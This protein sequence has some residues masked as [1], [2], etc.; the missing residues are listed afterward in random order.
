MSVNRWLVIGLAGLAVATAIDVAAGDEFV[1][2]IL[3]LLPVLGIAARAGRTEVAVIGTLATAVA[4]ASGVWDEDFG[5][6]VHVLGALSVAIGAGMAYLVVQSREQAE[7]ARVGTVSAERRLDEVLGALAE[8]IT[9]QDSDGQVVFANQAAADMIGFGS[10]KELIEA[11]AQE[12]AARFEMRRP[13]GSA[14]TFDELPGLRVLA[15]EPFAELLTRSVVKDTGEAHWFRTRATRLEDADGAYAVNVIEDVTEQREAELRQRYLTE[16]GELLS[17]SLDYEHT[18]QQVL[19]LVV[20]ELADWA[21]IEIPDDHEDMEQVAIAHVDPA[22]IVWAKELRERYPPDPDAPQGP[23]AIMR[24]GDPLLMPFIPPELLEEAAQDEEHLRLIRE[25]ELRSAMAVPMRSAGRPVGVLSLI[26]TAGG[27]IYDEDDLAFATALADRAGVAVE[28]ARL[29]TELSRVAETLQASLLPERLPDI[30]RWE[31]AAEYRAGE[32]GSSVGG[33]FYDVV[34]SDGGKHIALLGDVSGK[35]V[36]AA[37]LT[38]LVRHTART[39]AFFHASP[40]DILA[41]VNRA[42]RLQPQL[43]PVTMACASC[44]EDGGVSLAIGG[45]PLPV[46]RRADGQAERIGSFGLLLGVSEPYPT[47]AESVVRLERGDTLLIFTDGVTDTPGED[48]RFG[49]DRLR[50]AVATAPPEPA[51]LLA[52]ISRALDDYQS[53]TVA[54]DRAM[55]ALRYTG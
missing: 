8:A 49:D 15:G 27:R 13:D 23:R 7:Q 11:D 21:A 29:Y 37:A 55:L 32:R 10:P 1:L 5:E 28:N 33:D 48:G 25:L 53:G 42:L 43:S 36:E 9:V 4:L 19:D 51:G 54:D 26:A 52:S 41:L 18:L 16:A 14:V 30:P 45:H 47:Q 12:I 6:S 50:E 17:S 35:G 38:S 46:L 22:K 2:R 3:F 34:P 31:I 40:A 39:G 44:G 20:P 24:S